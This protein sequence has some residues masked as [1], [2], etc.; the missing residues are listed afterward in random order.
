MLGIQILSITFIFL[1]LYVIRIHYKKGELPKVEAIFWTLILLIVGIMVMV[2]QSAN[3]I[4][5]LFSVTRLT[6]VIVIFSLMG[7]FVL[8]I[9]SRIQINKLRTK[10][11]KLVR[12][13]AMDN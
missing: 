3:Y 8:M 2:E 4:R 5:S 13:R 1:M 7:V 9:E 10:L 6:D 12:D 11:D